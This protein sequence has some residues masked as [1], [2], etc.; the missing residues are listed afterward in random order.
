MAVVLDLKIEKLTL[1]GQGLGFIDGKACFVDGGIPGEVVQV[2]IVQDKKDYAVGRLLQVVKASAHRVKPECALFPRCGGC[3]LQHIEYA[4]QLRLKSAMFAETMRRVGKIE[5]E[6]PGVI[7]RK[8][9]HYRNRAQ[10]PVQ[11]GKPARIGYFERGSHRVVDQTTCPV[12]DARINKALR[13]LRERIAE[14]GI[15]AYDEKQHRGT[16]RH[17]IIKTGIRTGQTYVMFVTKD[18]GFPKHLVRGLA[19]DIPDLAG[20]AQNLNPGRTNRILGKQSQLLLGQDYYEERL[21]QITFRVG[22]ASFFQVNT[23]VFEAITSAIRERLAPEPRGTVLDLYSGVGAIGLCCAGAA[24]RVIGIEEAPAAVAE[25]RNN[26]AANKIANVE[27]RSGTVEKILPQ[28]AKAD[29]IILDPPRAGLAPAV[30][31]RLLA[32]KPR[33]LAYLSCDPA[34][35]AR[36]ARRLVNGGYAIESTQLFDMFPQTHHIESLVFFVPSPR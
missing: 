20:V 9:W 18:R 34:T 35:F 1:G 19:Q 21:E 13:V 32:L 27:F 15:T 28:I 29:A 6:N 10:L 36:D 7:H 22:P 5:M 33:L 31:E 16:L 2:S 3:Q 11:P 23:D 4:Q 12:H 17:L 24:E 26:A 30:I 25:A 8:E 14:S